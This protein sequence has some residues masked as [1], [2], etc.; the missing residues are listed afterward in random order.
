MKIT[1][2]VANAASTSA[3][4]GDSQNALRLNLPPKGD[5]IDDDNPDVFTDAMRKHAQF[6]ATGLTDE[7]LAPFKGGQRVTVTIEI[8]K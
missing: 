7:L 6:E 3:K 4:P 5:R 1:M 8:A 2:F